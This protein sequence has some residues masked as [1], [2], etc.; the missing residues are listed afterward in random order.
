VVV[1]AVLLVVLAIPTG[2]CCGEDTTIV[3]TPLYLP[4]TVTDAMGFATGFVIAATSTTKATSAI[5]T[6]TTTTDN[7]RVRSDTSTLLSFSIVCV[8]ILK[9][10]KQQ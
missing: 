4:A 9:K 8:R 1:V 2:C 3:H 5:A 10:N 7:G 6:T